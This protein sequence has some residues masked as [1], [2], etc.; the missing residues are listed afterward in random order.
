MVSLLHAMRRLTLSDTPIQRIPQKKTQLPQSNVSRAVLKQGV[1]PVF[2]T[3]PRTYRATDFRTYR[4]ETE[5]L[6]KRSPIEK[7]PSVIL[8]KISQYLRVNERSQYIRVSTPICRAV[9]DS[10]SDQID[11][12]LIADNHAVYTYLQ[13]GQPYQKLP[14]KISYFKIT[15]TRADLLKHLPQIVQRFQHLQT[16]DIQFFPGDTEDQKYLPSIF[17]LSQ[18]QTLT[19]RDAGRITPKGIGAL[20]Q[21]SRLHLHEG[22][23][24]DGSWI[25][26]LKTQKQ[27][28]ELRLYDC[29]FRDRNRV[30]G[31]IAELNLCTLRLHRGYD[32]MDFPMRSFSLDDRSF[33]KLSACSTFVCLDLQLDA[34]NVTNSGFIQLITRCQCLQE[35][36][37]G[38][39]DRITEEALLQIPKRT[40]L[41]SFYMSRTNMNKEQLTKILRE[42]NLGDVQIKNIFQ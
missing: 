11:K 28:K 38:R 40:K 17:Q 29:Y 23:I 32:T 2:G 41:R 26:E 19:L 35:L 7:L 37:L 5:P 1:Y 30:L 15:Q 22:L 8:S 27:L 39:C 14:E 31:H 20:H 18:L 34:V 9:C 4:A 10:G 16:L 3:D 13:A 24:G 6:K 42:I 33:E 12:R 36:Y 25:R 21:L